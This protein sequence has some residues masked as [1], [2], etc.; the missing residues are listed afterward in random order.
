MLYIFR[1]KHGK[2]TC[3]SRL[4]LGDAPG[5]PGRPHVT[6]VSDKEAFMI[7]EDPEHDGNCYTLAYRID[8]HR[9]GKGSSKDSL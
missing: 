7:W 1:N 5:R 9:P 8:W 6:K 4:L 2:V 3:R